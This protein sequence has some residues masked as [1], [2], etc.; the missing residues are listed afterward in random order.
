VAA[1]A[2]ELGYP[3]LPPNVRRVLTTLSSAGFEAVLVG[4]CV[5]DR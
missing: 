3:D 5:R 4:G 2:V 1:A